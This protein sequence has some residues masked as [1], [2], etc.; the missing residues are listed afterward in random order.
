M[1][2]SRFGAVVNLARDIKAYINPRVGIICCRA[3]RQPE[4]HGT[5]A[6]KPEKTGPVPLKANTMPDFVIIGAQKCGTT[7]LYNLLGQHPHVALAA[8]KEIHYFDHHFS[9]KGRGWYRA[10]FPSPTWKDG[11]K[12]ITGESS[13]YYL[14]HPHA[15]R[16]LA[17]V[18]PE[19]RLIVLLRNPVDRAYSHYH[20]EARRGYEPLTFEKA[21]EAE[22]ARVR[23]ERD[24]MLEDEHYA[25]FNHQHFSYLSR[26]LY[27][28]Q[29]MEWSRFFEDE[30]ML[31]LKSE[32]LF[33]Q[34]SNA[35]RSVLDFLGLP[36]Y[37]PE[38][39]K[40]YLEGRYPPMDPAT[41]RR[42]EDFFE[43]HNRRLYEYLGVDFG[44]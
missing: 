30:Q 20:Q 25:S 29:L 31:V 42:L 44:W 7:F 26:G 28:D 18:V 43:P 1:Q 6:R 34:A 10:H 5:P 14:F 19:A 41:R 23:V 4:Q 21:I 32:D 37:E 11:R 16:R 12:S 22:E 27:V 39:T 17:Q 40:P 13:P 9:N 24:K 15:A 35:L 2:I 36:G 3:K 33:G 38:A 8:K